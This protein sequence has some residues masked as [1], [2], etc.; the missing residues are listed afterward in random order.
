M[1]MQ[2][3]AR[4]FDDLRTMDLQEV[5]EQSKQEVLREYAFRIRL[6]AANSLGK[7]KSLVFE[8]AAGI[9]RWTAAELLE[10]SNRLRLLSAPDGETR[11]Y[12]ESRNSEFRS[13]PRVREFYLLALNKAGRSAEAILECRRL[14]AE[15]GENGL[16]LGILGDACSNKMLSAE[17]FARELGPAEGKISLV[18]T[19]V[20]AEFARHFPGVNLPAI[21]LKGVRSL[22][23]QCLEDAAEAYRRG[24]ERFGTAFP[25]FCWMLRTGDRYADLCAERDAA[26][27]GNHSEVSGT[28]PKGSRREVEAEIAK[29]RAI[30]EVQPALLRMALEMGGGTE[31]LDFW[32]HAGYL[33]LYFHEGCTPEEG[34]SLPARALATLD[35][36]FKLE[37]LL[38]DLS[39]IRDQFAKIPDGE[40]M[41]CPETGARIRILERMQS[42][43]AGLAAGRERFAA[44]GRTR[45]SALSETWRKLLGRDTADPVMLFLKRTINF[46]TLTDT[47][48][49]QR[50]QGGIGRVGARMPDLIINRQV[51]DDLLSLI[52][53]NILPSLSAGERTQPKAVI[54]AI[55]RLVGA[56]LGVA[57]LQDLQSPEHREFDARSDGLILLSGIDPVMRV[58]SRS[59]TALT[60]AMLLNTGDC[61]ET[62]YLNGALFALYQQ[63]QVKA[64]LAE[65][66][67]HM[68]RC[69]IDEARRITGVEIPAILRYQLRGGH[70]AVYVEAI[71]MEE[72]YKV[73]RASADDPIA[74]E[75]CYGMEEFKAGQPLTRYE[76][77]NAKIVLGYTDGTLR[78]IEP[79]DDVSGR[80]RPIPHL[81][82]DGGGIP[83]IPH[84]G[85]HGGTVE[86]IRLLNL[87][88]EHSLCFFHDSETGE[89]ELCDGFYN[90]QLFDS[91]Y[92]FGSGRIDT[93][94]PLVRYGL[95]RAGTRRV[96]GSDGDVRD[97]QVF[98]EFLPYSTTDYVPCL[99]EGDFP[100]CF[101]LMG[102][103]FRGDLREERRRI[104]EGTS[105]IPSVLE[106]MRAWQVR[107]GTVI[108]QR[109]VLDQRFVRVL[110]ELARDRP[111]LVVL[112]D[113]GRERHLITQGCEGASV[114][115]VLCG[116]FHVY[117]DEKLVMKDDHPFTAP[118]GT[119]LGEISALRGC[120]PTATVVGEG[121]VLRIAKAEFKRQMEMNAVFRE[122]VEE[123]IS[124]RL[125]SDR[126]RHS[127]GSGPRWK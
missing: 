118:P 90:E 12:E 53:E 32:T 127:T 26:L 62:M 84:F 125:E 95:L 80:W 7:L 103:L 65:A 23:R 6:D 4:T 1:T 74:M 71:T 46:R 3:S 116:R 57:E 69:S 93:C 8:G 121:T 67:K 56:W 115:L 9:D 100:R 89:I 50:I 29:L 35:A 13:I 68:E 119:V 52:T 10:I 49:P 27:A 101:Q 58:G 117:Q 48:V 108:R 38:G 120:L 64:K 81:T 37:F 113:V 47:L 45:G 44:S 14:L 107:Q 98:L 33:Q 63:M 59:T 31:S 15:G 5:Y 102:R 106:R 51:R 20:K 96:R 42:V 85:A 77:E 41:G 2:Q 79:R 55:R 70:V 40:W 82:A 21:T 25:G 34:A 86:I 60:A 43:L 16:V 19:Q 18:A 112:E 73:K 104:E 36:V 97:H 94:D 11:L 83:V 22:R 75:R 24:F 61:R 111:E 76:L 105:A 28:Q 109:Q 54:S 88:E 126:L 30:L 114:Y 39:R 17:K 123:L 122:S 110:L 124:M 99:E 92:S 87:V 78:V 72:K 91:P 66:M